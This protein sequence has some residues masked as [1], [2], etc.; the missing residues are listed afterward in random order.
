MDLA[1]GPDGKLYVLDNEG[2]QQTVFRYNAD[3]TSQTVYAS[4]PLS[5]SSSAMAFGPDGLLYVS[6]YDAF[7]PSNLQ[8]EIL[9]ISNNGATITPYITGLFNPG[10]I[11]FVPEPGTLVLL[12]GGLPLLLRRRRSRTG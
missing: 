7:S 4:F 9:Q 12:S 5:F 8:G 11:T 10:F 1:F 6:G 2:T 3:G